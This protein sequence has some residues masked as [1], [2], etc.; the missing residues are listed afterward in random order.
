MSLVGKKVPNIQLQAV[1]GTEELPTMNFETLQGRY[2]LFFFYPL[3]FTFVCPTELHAF[4]EVLSQ[5]EER[6]CSVMGC[7]VDSKYS[8]LAWLRTP[9]NEGGIEGVSYPLVADLNKEIARSFGV[10]DEQSGVAYRGL[11]LID[12]EGIVRHQIVNDLFIGR[13]SEE[14]LRCLDALI[15]HENHGV[16][17]PA[18]WKAGKKAIEPNLASTASYLSS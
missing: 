5:F 17:C 2:V 9:K 15:H 16:V 3:D 6:N 11:F 18:N 13:S 1:Q 7:S 12:K 14:A 4:E 10:L 8:H